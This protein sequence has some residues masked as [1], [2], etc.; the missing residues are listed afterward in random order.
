MSNGS[1]KPIIRR[2]ARAAG[3]VF[4]VG[5][6]VGLVSLALSLSRERD[7]RSEQQR[8]RQQLIER[9]RRMLAELAKRIDRLPVD[10]AVIGDI[11]SRYYEE[12]PKARLYVWAFDTSGGFLFG[13]PAEAFAR[14]NAAYDAN[15]AQ[16]QQDGHF[17]NRQEFLREL[18]QSNESLSLGPA[19]ARVHSTGPM[20]P[21]WWFYRD[22]NPDHTMLSTPIAA[23]DGSVLG[24]LYM[25]VVP[26]PRPWR[27]EG[28]FQV[29]GS[30]GGAVTMLS[31]LFLWFLLP[32][33][34]YVD[35]SERGVRR[36][37][38]WSFLVLISFVVGLVVYLIARPE[39]PAALTCPGCGREING[40]AFCPYC[41]RDVSTAF[42]VTCRYPLKPDWSYCPSCRAPIGQA[43]GLGE[44][45]SEAARNV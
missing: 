32:T 18:I 7:Q 38:L 10:P 19:E 12:Q 4:I 11:E 43:S 24:S 16:I 2:M 14:L 33:W 6:L 40:G 23:Q 28:F 21:E 31:G 13:V 29:T 27:S 15:R 17:A 39:H 30:I 25:K 9:S 5:G 8:R 37:A 41:G 34:V 44:T 45:Q 22:T 3:A 20:T 1:K 36:A 26:G 35:A 42:C